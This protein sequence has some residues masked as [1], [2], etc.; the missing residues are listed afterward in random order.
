MTK[1]PVWMDCDTGTDD[2][3]AIMLATYLEEIEVLG[4]STAAGNTI[5]EN[6]YWNTHRINRLIGTNYPVYRGAE[7][8]L[9]VPL[10][11]GEHIHGANGL[12]DVEIPLPDDPVVQKESAWD[13]LYACAKAHPHELRLVPT[14]PLWH[15]MRTILRCRPT[16]LRLLLTRRSLTCR[17]YAPSRP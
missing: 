17:R 13:A 4:I 6:A 15:G 5:Q 3:V 7:K 8:P 2:A 12:G 16:S 11:T 1:I 9:I 14:A 10:V